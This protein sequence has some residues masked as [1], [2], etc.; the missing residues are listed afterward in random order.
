MRSG[1]FEG[2]AVVCFW[3]AFM[4]V[5]RLGLS[6]NAAL[7][8]YDM[9]ALRLG[10]AALVLAP[11]S[12]NIG[13]LYWRSWRL[14]VLAGLN[15]VVYSLLV[16]WGFRLAPATHGAV[17]FPGILPFETAVLSW[18]LLG[19]RPTQGQWGGMCL[20][21]LGLACLAPHLLADGSRGT[22]P[23]DVLL[24]GSSVVWAVYGVLARRWNVDAWLLTRFVALAA[25]FVYLPVY[26]C[27][28]PKN[29]G[30]VGLESLAG[31]GLYHGLLTT[32]LVMWL[33]LRA[34]EKLGAAR[35]GALMALVPALSGSLAALMLGE[36]MP[37]PLVAALL[38]V[39]MGAWLATRTC[40]S[41]FQSQCSAPS[42][43]RKFQ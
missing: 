7:T 29:L 36:D 12:R 30:S 21:G 17:L 27:F 11:F 40:I 19:R 2:F 39:S 43:S 1:Y 15:G 33:Y 22:L 16:Y 25:A 18:W 3:S 32:V 13:G 42:A 34:Q 8:P 4:L 41:P 37:A 6:G 38:C 20:I 5:S 28:L 23:G 31:Q 24:V 10:T 26:A 14:W 9:T 35:L